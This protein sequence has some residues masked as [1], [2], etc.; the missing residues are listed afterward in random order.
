MPAQVPQTLLPLPSFACATKSRSGSYR[1][2]FLTRSAIVVDS[3]PGTMSAR[4]RARSAGVR[5]RT[6]WTGGVSCSSAWMCSA[7]EPWR[8]L[9]RGRA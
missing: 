8:A 9:R 1:P 7:N 6:T 2:D 4:Q 3:P 5:T